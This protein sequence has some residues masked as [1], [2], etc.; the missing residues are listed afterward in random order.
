[1]PKQ[2]GR[3]V[4]AAANQRFE[5]IFVEH[6]AAVVAYVRRRAPAEAVDDAVGETFLVAWRRLS[7][8]PQE[9]LP[10]L[11]TV[12]R[13]VLATQRRGSRRRDALLSRLRGVEPSPYEPGLAS[14]DG[15]GRV[16][17]ALG[18]LADRDREALTL[19]AWDGLTPEQAAA[20][21]R[22]SPG[23]FRVRL[24]RARK[25][26]RQQLDEGDGAAVTPAVTDQ[27]LRIGGARS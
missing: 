26:L 22:E 27:R 2:H 19:T 4:G 23:T 24:H 8:V 5:Q 9:P 11:L 21:L 16:L 7:R 6:H 3:P 12:A 17:E 1:M 10:W 15:G 20:V 18:R 14:A 25:R 13:N